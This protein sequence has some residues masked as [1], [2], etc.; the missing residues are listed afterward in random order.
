[1]IERIVVAVDDSS[2][3]LGAAEYAIR[4]AETVPARL[5]VVTIADAG[6]KGVALL[7]HVQESAERHGVDVVTTLRDDHPAFEA[8]LD[9][10]HDWHADLVVMG[11]SDDRRPGRHYVGSETEHLLE[12]TDLPVLVVPGP[13]H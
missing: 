7:R 1:M 13:P 5:H 4:L 11:R 9:I 10:A 6:S 2:A 12:F 8:I 3:A